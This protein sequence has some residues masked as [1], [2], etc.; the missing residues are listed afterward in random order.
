[1]SISK[2][3]TM[4]LFV[5]L[6]SL[7]ASKALAEPPPHFL[8]GWGTLGLG[9]GEFNRPVALTVHSDGS[10]YVVDDDNHR[11]QRF[12][13]EGHFLT[14][15]GSN[16]SEDTEFNNPSGI[17]VDGDGF[18]YVADHFNQAIK[19][20]TADGAF[21]ATF[22]VAPACSNTWCTSEPLDVA[23]DAN[24]TIY[25]ADRGR[26][27]QL[28]STGV[29][30]REWGSVGIGIDEFRRPIALELGLDDLLYVTDLFNFRVQCFLTDGTFL[31]AWGSQG[32]EPSQFHAPTS[33]AVDGSGFVYV[34][35]PF[36]ERIQKFD[37]Q[38]TFVSMWGT[39][40]DGPSEFDRP[41][42]VAVGPNGEIYVADTGNH[43][44]QVF[45][46]NTAVLGTT[47][48]DIKVRFKQPPN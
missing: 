13:S 25:V 24:G 26:I 10:V 43:R 9:D 14:K 1:M 3:L 28:S 22:E 44:I 8:R 47:W 31:R 20:F 17:T 39:H 2:F 4:A 37:S 36:N 32:S 23:V 6:F 41:R 16:G 40:G 21:I 42:G 7:V 48:G 19:K 18:V 38:G 15:W 11:I 35:D 33:V 5:P 29:F 45:G 30:Q 12:D 27:V 34:A 46:V